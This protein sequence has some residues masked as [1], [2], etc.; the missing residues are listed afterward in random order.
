M[1]MALRDPAE[2]G[3]DSF[4]RIFD[5][6]SARP[7][8]NVIQFVTGAEWLNR[9]SLYPRQAT[10]LKI[11]FLQTEIFTEFDYRVIDEWTKGFSLNESKRIES[12]EDDAVTVTFDGQWGIVPDILDRIEYLRGEGHMWFNVVLAV[13][14]RRSGKGHLGGL[15]GS[16]V[17]WHYIAM[18]NAR[19]FFGIDRD[20]RFASQVFAGKKAQARDNQWRDIANVILGAPCFEPFISSP[21]TDTL[22]VF[23]QNDLLSHV[24]QEAKANLSTSKK[25]T[26]ATTMDTATF[27]VAA[28]E[29]TTM[30][31][32]GPASFMQFYDEGAHMVATGVSRSMGEVWET[33]TPS[34]DQFKPY[35]FIYSGSS[36]WTMDGKFYELC[37]NTLTVEAD[38]HEPVYPEQMM[39]Q[40]ESWD[41][42]QDW[43]L[44][45]DGDFL[46]CP[47]HVSE[48]KNMRLGIEDDGLTTPP[49]ECP[50]IYAVPLRK[51]IQVY[52]KA[53]RRKER[54][55][56]HTFKVEYRAQWATGLDTYFP[57]EHVKRM[58]QPWGKETLEQKTHGNPTITY[59]MHG[60]P[61]KTGSNFGFAVAHK[62]ADP[63]GHPI[64]HVVFDFVRGWQPF[65]FPSGEMDYIQIESEIGE[66]MDGFL[67][68]DVTFDQWN[69]ISMIQRLAARSRNTFKPASVYERSATA[70]INWRTAETTKV[71]LSLNRVH[72]VYSELAEL[73]FRFLRKLPGD[74][75]DHPSTGPCVT[76]DVYDAMSICIYKLIGQDVA[77]AYGEAFSALTLTG[78]APGG[79]PTASDPGGIHSQQGVRQ[80]QKTVADQFSRF[81]QERMAER[82]QRGYGGR[83]GR[84]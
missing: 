27:E 4:F 36:P 46:L 34:L 2:D 18:P 3:L 15:G 13:Q 84:P 64:P 8:P 50:D 43:E 62:V 73:E 26:P 37:Q 59:V 69:S 65:D 22:T 54:A 1:A 78:T 47:A 6:A 19:E 29:A 58:F 74:K 77:I 80:P 79:M 35:G 61:G 72:S 53:A 31:A 57:E 23:S 24:N 7:I 39:I 45:K 12:D 81:T 60:D 68:V 11:I 55:N 71:A 70:P 41:I 63:D 51:A 10:L 30:A 42:Y 67:P 40:L 25:S 20:K 9:P 82:R 32:R 44:T 48:G 28:R 66:L 38:T 21:L 49:V 14:G 76:K 56:P 52:D 17:L 33:A 83:R 5:N 75:V 16:Y